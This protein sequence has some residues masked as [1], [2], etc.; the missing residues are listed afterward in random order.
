MQHLHQMRM[1]QSFGQYSQLGFSGLNSSHFGSSPNSSDH[2]VFELKDGRSIGGGKAIESK[3]QKRKKSSN[4]K[5]P[6]TAYLYFVSKYREEVKNA[7]NSMPKQAKEMMQECAAKWRAMSDDEKKPYHELAGID[8]VHLFVFKERWLNEKAAEK[9]PKDQWRPKRPPSAYFLFLKDFR[10]NWKIDSANDTAES[11]DE[12]ENKL[13]I[14]NEDDED[15]AKLSICENENEPQKKIKID[16][17]KAK[18]LN[19][20]KEITKRA[21]SKWNSMSEEEK[22]PYVAKALETRVKWEK[23]L[24]IY[25]NEIKN[26]KT[27]EQAAEKLNDLTEGGE[28]ALN[29][30][31]ADLPSKMLQA[32]LPENF[33]KNDVDSSS[34][35]I[36]PDL[37]ISD[38]PNAH[39]A[40][41]SMPHAQSQLHSSPISAFPANL[42][43]LQ[44]TASS[45][46]HSEIM[47]QYLSHQNS[48]ALSTSQTI[49][50]NQSSFGH[51]NQ[52]QTADHHQ[53]QQNHQSQFEPWQPS[54][55][56]GNADGHTQR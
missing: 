51:Q 54:L 10:A 22:A 47:N 21:G 24:Q 41:S 53:P 38:S 30:A 9:K 23:Q 19:P 32:P 6:T 13:D 42:A 49:F 3:K 37:S 4:V 31:V 1:L 52:Q 27:G 26:G 44:Q 46:Q 36:R 16:D 8:K 40:V 17:D 5:R 12:N 15:R 45:I 34:K 48:E 50:Q 55:F 2:S 7:G 43:S 39:Q 29:E 28:S 35:L 33:V 25:K 18:K 56:P 11:E 14:K 20:Q